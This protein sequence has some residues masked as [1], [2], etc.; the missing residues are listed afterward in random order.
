MPLVEQSIELY[1]RGN[2]IYIFIDENPIE[3]YTYGAIY[4]NVWQFDVFTHFT[5]FLLKDKKM[6]NA[7]NIL[8]PLKE[9]EK[10][11]DHCV[12]MCPSFTNNKNKLYLIK[13]RFI[14]I[15]SAIYKHE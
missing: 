8:I 10:A 7:K 11:N 2:R 6:F 1:I 9:F 3:K 13:N 5:N 4:G 12:I 14:L 15:G